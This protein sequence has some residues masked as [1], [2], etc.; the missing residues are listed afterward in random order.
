MKV[1]R[2][3]DN[4]GRVWPVEITVQTV[5]DLR[6]SLDVEFY[7]VVEADSDLLA[8]MA[9][10]AV[11]LCDVLYVVCSQEC[12]ARG[13]SD[14]EFGRG[15]HG[16]AISD[17]TEA[18]FEAVDAFFQNARQAVIARTLTS[19]LRLARMMAEVMATARNKDLLQETL[20]RGFGDVQESSESTPAASV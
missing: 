18:F 7:S 12:V 5:K 11:L 13:V 6:R 4:Q 2:F 20:K 1:P 10:D 3:T 14:E 17:A 9:T 19:N 16:V 8:R 15:L